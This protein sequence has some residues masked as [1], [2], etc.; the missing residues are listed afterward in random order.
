VS[1]HDLS[2]STG[3][4]YRVTDP[5]VHPAAERFAEHS[6][7]DPVELALYGGEE[8]E[9]VFSFKPEERD[10]VQSALA[11]V[12]CGLYIIGEVTEEKGITLDHGRE[13]K[14]IGPGGWIH[15]TK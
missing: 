3:L 6:G 8:Y 12:G 14:P 10:K 7:L 11:G 15:F 4:G 13:A 9:L 2:R 1:L 5:P